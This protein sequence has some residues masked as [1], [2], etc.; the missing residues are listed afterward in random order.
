MILLVHCVPETDSS[1]LLCFREPY[2]DIRFNLM[3]VVPD[4]RQLYEQKLSTLRTNHKIV[5][6]AM[7][8]VRTL[9]CHGR[10]CCAWFVVEGF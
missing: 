4:K 5:L 6:E 2:H 8:Q 7:Q 10:G 9:A 1:G 3:V